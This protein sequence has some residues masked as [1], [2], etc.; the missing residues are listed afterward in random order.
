M[1]VVRNNANVLG[2]R[3]KW[4]GGVRLRSL[5][6]LC[7]V[8]LRSDSYSGNDA[9][10]G[11]GPVGAISDKLLAYVYKVPKYTQVCKCSI[12]CRRVYFDAFFTILYQT[13][14]STI[15]LQAHLH[16]HGII[17]LID[18]RDMRRYT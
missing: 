10:H 5:Y 1:I 18:K 16:T 7:S 12:S 2:L 3:E 8:D 15:S 17:S 4:T 11:E 6:V 14:K 9:G 13:A